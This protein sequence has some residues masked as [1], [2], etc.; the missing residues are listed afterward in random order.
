VE[1]FQDRHSAQ[2]VSTHPPAVTPVK[3]DA[4]ADTAR[5]SGAAAG[6]ANRRQALARQPWVSYALVLLNVTVWLLTLAS[7]A[8]LLQAPA[9]KMLTWGGNAASEVQRGEWWRL[10]TAVFLHSGLMHLTMN[11]AGLLCTGPTVERVYGSRR[12]LLLYLGAGLIGSALSLHFS[13]QH[14]TAVGASGAVFGVAGALLVAALRH[15]RFLP[16]MLSFY[17][18]AGI[19]L[20]LLDGMLRGFGSGRVDNAAH[21]GGLLA[22]CLLA[23]ILPE[24][25]SGRGSASQARHRTLAAGAAV[26]A[27]TVLLAVSAPPAAV[28]VRGAFQAGSAMEKALRDFDMI[29]TRMALEERAANAGRMTQSLRVLRQQTVHAQALHKTGEELAAIRLPASDLRA[30]LLADLQRMVAL[31]EDLARMETGFA[32]NNAPPPPADPARRAEILREVKQLR[33]RIVS[34]QQTHASAQR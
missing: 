34:W 26:L 18:L 32:R 28:D 27:A 29:M 21:V 13:A 17:T 25:I 4:G 33:A 24:R 15:R 20:L 11:M 9:E 10:L 7:G 1:P 22:G 19:G 12:F 16:T 5:Q 8:A 31:M 30:P 3:A 14:G 2:S 23:L 6:F